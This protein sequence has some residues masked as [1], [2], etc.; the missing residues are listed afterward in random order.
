MTYRDHYVN[1]Q[2]LQ[3]GRFARKAFELARLRRAAGRI[4]SIPSRPWCSS[5]RLFVTP[6]VLVVRMSLSK[7]AAAEPATAAS[8]SRRTTFRSGTT[9]CSGRRWASPSS[10]PCSS[11]FCCSGLGLGLAMLVQS[12]EPLGQSAAHG[13]PAAGVARPRRRLAAG[14]RLLLPGRSARSVRR[15]K[16]SD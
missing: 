10:T 1:D 9:G 14:L 11:P 15:L 4:S 13:V 2:E 5:A 6:L 12:A 16:R 7:L 3:S 8:I